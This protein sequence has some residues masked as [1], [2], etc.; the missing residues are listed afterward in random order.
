MFEEEFCVSV[1]Y[2]V[3]ITNAFH[4]I[5]IGDRSFHIID[6][7]LKVEFKSHQWF[8]WNAA[9]WRCLAWSLKAAATASKF[10]SK[11]G[12]I[13]RLNLCNCAWAGFF[14]FYPLNCAFRSDVRT[15]TGLVQTLTLHQKRNH[16]VIF[17]SHINK[18]PQ[19]VQSSI[20]FVHIWP[21]AWY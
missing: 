3:I 21:S 20:V 18:V 17:F 4:P 2:Y 10:F 12:P 14:F 19:P 15:V 1:W 5:S 13:N 16:K 9:S 11:F 6:R 8:G 7:D